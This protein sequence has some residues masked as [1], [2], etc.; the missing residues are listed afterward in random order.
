[1]YDYRLSLLV[2][3]KV[4]RRQVIRLL[5]LWRIQRGSRRKP[6]YKGGVRIEPIQ[7]GLT[8]VIIVGHTR[9]KEAKDRKSIATSL[10][11]YLVRRLEL[12]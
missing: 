11:R 12:G 7:D 5:S 1:M 4:N 8:L 9:V 6:T 2:A 3:G 10:K